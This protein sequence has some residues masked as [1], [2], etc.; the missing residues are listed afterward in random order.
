MRPRRG[1]RAAPTATGH[2]AEP[3]RRR[4]VVLGFMESAKSMFATDDLPRMRRRRPAPLGLALLAFTAIAPAAGVRAQSCADFTGVAIGYR[5]C[6]SAGQH[7]F[8][9]SLNVRPFN[10]C[11][12]PLPGHLELRVGDAF[13]ANRST[14]WS[15]PCSWPRN[16]WP[17]QFTVTLS[18]TAI[19]SRKVVFEKWVK[20]SGSNAPFRCGTPFQFHVE[21]C[22]ANVRVTPQPLGIPQGSP[23]YM[24]C[25]PPR[26]GTAFTTIASGAFPNQPGVWVLGGMPVQIPVGRYLLF[27]DPAAAVY[28]PAA[29]STEGE[30]ALTLPIP[31]DPLLVGLDLELQFGV[32]D[33][34]Q[35]GP[36]LSNALT[37]TI[38]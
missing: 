21:P 14:I 30:A 36:A 37:A 15:T 1:R 34:A 16:G 18:R 19:P 6:N 38:F 13:S 23:V 22:V 33:P 31:P 20:P 3:G 35:Q 12:A 29:T 11:G 17:T 2:G 28:V 10:N 25:T 27:V 4:F 8:G 7:V 24:P 9:V 32:L 26:T 5:G